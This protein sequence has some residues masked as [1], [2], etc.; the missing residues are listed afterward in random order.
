[1]PSPPTPPP[2]A[3]IARERLRTELRD[4][5]AELRSQHHFRAWLRACAAMPRYSPT[6]VM[7]ITTQASRCGLEPGAAASVPTWARLGYAP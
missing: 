5:V 1:V 6:T 2:S 4:A 3:A 7:L